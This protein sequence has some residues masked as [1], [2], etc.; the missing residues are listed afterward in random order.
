MSA[1][2]EY[3]GALRTGLL[4]AMA[5]PRHLVLTSAGF[6]IAAITL[7]VLLTLPAGLEQL[8][9]HTGSNDTAVVLPGQGIDEGS[10]AFSVDQLHVLQT[11]PG[12][13]HDGRGRPLVAAQFVAYAKLRQAD[14]RMG[15]VLLRGVTPAFYRVFG[16]SVTLAQGHYPR[17]GH[18][19]FIAGSGAIA[20]YVALRSGDQT[21]IHH[22]A[23]HSVGV[24]NAGAG[25]WNSEIWMSQDVLQS[26]Y[27]QPSAI[28]SVW[29]KLQSPD[30]YIKFL[31]ALRANRSLSGVTATPQR[32]FYAGQTRFLGHYVHIATV[33]VA[34]VLGLGA[35]L[36]IT[37]ALAISL[38][39]RRRELAIMRATGFQQ[40]SLA[41]ALLTEVWL[42][43]MVCVGMVALAAF[44]FWNGHSIESSTLLHAVSFKADVSTK[45]VLLTL[46]YTLM[47]GTISA[48]I[49][50]VK[51]VRAPLV[52]ALHNT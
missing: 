44:V 15:T 3:S 48:L 20:S 19:E 17:V 47:I 41:W 13:A 1:L 24:F 52:N 30:A 38:S 22:Q 4:S 49:P 43:G 25:F 45:V 34:I 35:I 26:L 18:E 37:N 28:T 27:G 12:I 42:L 23:M 16:S 10:N 6:L 21:R 5:R 9:G 8:A 14:G 36:A 39:A 33:S 51:A 31:H 40:V 46:S 50:I 32:K 11:L 2:R 29:V 7:L